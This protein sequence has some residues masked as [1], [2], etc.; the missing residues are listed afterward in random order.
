MAGILLVC[1][2]ALLWGTTGVAN[3]LMTDRAVDPALVGLTRTSLG[4]LTLLLAAEAIRVPWTQGRLPFRL[5]AV[6]GLAGAVFQTCLFAAFAEVGVTVT[7]AVTVCAPV[8]LVLAGEAAWC[9]FW[10]EKGV[11]VATGLAALGVGL[12]MA[13]GTPS[14]AMAE[15]IAWRGVALL[16]A[17]SVAY[18]A[19]AAVARVI[20]RDLHP[21]RATGLGLAAT[22]AVLAVVV[23]GSGAEVSRLGALPGSDLALL[24]YTGVAATGCAYFAFVLGMH[25]SRT[26]ASGLAATLIEPGVAAVLAAWLLRERLAPPERLGCVLMLAAM[27]VLF[28]AERQSRRRAPT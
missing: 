9:R 11:V 26:A 17:A 18:A 21:L 3:S 7:V 12:A 1:V 27:V 14:S 8:V 6:F 16:A 24:A 22:A 5:L 15:D 10:P 19:V 13:G 2:A 4:A 28:V 25:L 23:L 20:A